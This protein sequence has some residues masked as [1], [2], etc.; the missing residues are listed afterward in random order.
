[1]KIYTSLVSAFFLICSTFS[2][3]DGNY[4]LPSYSQ[5]YSFER[6]PFEDL[7]TASQ[8]AKKDGRLVLLIV[9]GEWCRWCHTLDRFIDSDE[10]YR[11]LFY[12]TFEV[13]KIYYG[14]KNENKEFL[15]KLP[16][17]EGYPHFFVLNAEMEILGS[18]DTGSLERHKLLAG[19]RDKY[20][21]RNMK[22]FL[23]YWEKYLKS[24]LDKTLY[25]NAFNDD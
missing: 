16:K 15:S 10:Q 6:D 3:A 9:G 13:V 14:P 11:K 4:S 12:K 5:T 7:S 21:K 24:S 17:I 23:E 18:Q 22:V 25:S 19:E 20:K 2:V 8:K 1:M